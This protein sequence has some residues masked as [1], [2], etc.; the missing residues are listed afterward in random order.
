MISEISFINQEQEAPNFSGFFVMRLT[1]DIP[2]SV[3]HAYITKSFRNKVL[4]FKSKK[5]VEYINNLIIL[6]NRNKIAMIDYDI[7]LCINVYFKKRVSDIDNILK[8]LLDSLQQ[9]QI[10]KNDSL[11]KK[12]YIEIQKSNTK[13]AYISVNIYKI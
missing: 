1:L 7:F 5:F 2:V 10:V 12:L 11:I 9:S 4:R 3:N 13:I 6:K 8:V